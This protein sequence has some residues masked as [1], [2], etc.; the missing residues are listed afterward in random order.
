[1]KMGGSAVQLKILFPKSLVLIILPI[2]LDLRYGVVWYEHDF[3]LPL[4]VF[5]FIHLFIYL[6]H[7]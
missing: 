2:G 5:I 4:Y 3:L 7:Q 1:M 6:L